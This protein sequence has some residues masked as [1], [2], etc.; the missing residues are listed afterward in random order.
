MIS[1]R[2]SLR[3]NTV[4]MYGVADARTPMSTV[5]NVWQTL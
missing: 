5:D 3:M 2:T 1:K 4:V